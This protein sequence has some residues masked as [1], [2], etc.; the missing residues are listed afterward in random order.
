[1]KTKNLNLVNIMKMN[2]RRRDD[3]NETEGAK[4]NKRRCEQQQNDTLTNFN[5]PNI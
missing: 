2:D 1:M 3:E 5:N 4:K